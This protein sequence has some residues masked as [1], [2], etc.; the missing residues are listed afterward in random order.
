MTPSKPTQRPWK[1][2]LTAFQRKVWI[3]TH[4]LLSSFVILFAISTVFSYTNIITT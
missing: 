4:L 2:P 3:C 1:T